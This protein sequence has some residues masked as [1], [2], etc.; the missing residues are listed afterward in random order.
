MQVKL[1]H[2]TNGNRPANTVLVDIIDIVKSDILKKIEE[3]SSFDDFLR[4]LF[5]NY[6]EYITP[7]FPNQ[8]H[9][10]IIKWVFRN[11]SKG[12]KI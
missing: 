12:I 1:A 3:N 7:R 10:M 4:V 5:I 9:K 2:Y 6:D 11:L 8:N